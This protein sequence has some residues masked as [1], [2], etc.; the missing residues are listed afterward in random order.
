MQNEFFPLDS[1]PEIGF[2]TASS[3]FRVHGRGVKLVGD[4]RALW[5]IRRR[6]HF[7]QRV[8]S[9]PSCGKCG[10]L[11]W[12]SRRIPVRPDKDL[13]ERVWILPAMIAAFFRVRSMHADKFIRRRALVSPLRM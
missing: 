2:K 7:Y 8:P 12:L 6:P 9:F 1:L 11:C 13:K 10:F 3:G 5:L 4:C